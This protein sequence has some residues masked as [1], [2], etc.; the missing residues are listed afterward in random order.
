MKEL[1]EKG[2][3]FVKNENVNTFVNECERIGIQLHGG[4]L[5]KNGQWFYIE[6]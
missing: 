5:C 2:I 3:T 1:L 4:E 6:K